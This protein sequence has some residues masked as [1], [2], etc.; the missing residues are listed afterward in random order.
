MKRILLICCLLQ[1]C[2]ISLIGQKD[3]KNHPWT[4]GT[5][6]L[7][8]L[9]KYERTRNYHLHYPLSFGLDIEY[10]INDQFSISLGKS[11]HYEKI[12]TIPLTFGAPPRL[13]YGYSTTTISEIPIQLKY[14]YT[15]DKTK[16]FLPF[17]KTAL[18]YSFN[19][20]YSET[21]FV[22]QD[23]ITYSQ[24]EYY[25]FWQLGYGEIGRAS[26]RERV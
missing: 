22:S 1:Y 14:F 24:D 3:E 20:I 4:I 16:K 18:I 6:Y 25:I 17:F 7:P 9:E 15:K 19:S 5:S 8:R 26:C 13:I 10:R 21:L 2:C 12:K 23:F 11:L